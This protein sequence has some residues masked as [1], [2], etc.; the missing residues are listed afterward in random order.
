MRKAHAARTA[1][2]LFLI[3][4]AI[5]TPNTTHITFIDFAI[6]SLGCVKLA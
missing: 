2:R 4:A 3:A 6:N 1:Y 5:A